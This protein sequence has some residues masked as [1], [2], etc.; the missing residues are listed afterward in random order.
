ML[1]IFRELKSF[2]VNLFSLKQLGRMRGGVMRHH[3][4]FGMNIFLLWFVACCE[5]T[6]VSSNSLTGRYVVGLINIILGR[7][8][9]VIGLFFGQV[10]D[11]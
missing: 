7:N 2:L 11:L 10:S 1:I 6:H 4:S 8:Q 3:H 9:M 5:L